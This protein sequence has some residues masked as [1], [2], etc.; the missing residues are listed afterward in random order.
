MK[1]RPELKGDDL[2]DLR[3]AGV[4]EEAEDAGAG[5]VDQR[6]HG[7]AEAQVPANVDA[8]VGADGHPVL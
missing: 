2:R 8:V 1:E 3:P 6:R 4:A 5:R 7:Q